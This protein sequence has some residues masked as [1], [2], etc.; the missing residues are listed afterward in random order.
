[1]EDIQKDRGERQGQKVRKIEG[2]GAPFP[3]RQ[4]QDW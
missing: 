1:M 2:L 3:T 4:G